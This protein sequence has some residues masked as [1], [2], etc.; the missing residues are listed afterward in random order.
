MNEAE[1]VLASLEDRI[2][3]SIAKEYHD[4]KRQEQV[5]ETMTV[6]ELLNRLSYILPYHK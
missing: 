3:D 2:K 1:Q 6:P 5:Y 4:P